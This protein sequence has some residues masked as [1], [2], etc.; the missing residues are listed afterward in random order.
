M[1]AAGARGAPSCGS[2]RIVRKGRGSAARAEGRAIAAAGEPAV[3]QLDLS[4]SWF[5]T[6]LV[7]ALSLAVQLLLVQS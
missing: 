6:G 2:S 5:P 1:V 7:R 4:G 3:W